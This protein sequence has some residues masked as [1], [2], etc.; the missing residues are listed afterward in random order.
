[1]AAT[2][3]D[4]QAQ[5]QDGTFREDLWFR[6]SV[7]KIDIPPLRERRE[8]VVPLAEGILADL[9]AELGKRSATLSA[10]ARARLAAYAFPGNVRE[11]RNLL[12]RALVLEQGPE[13]ALEMLMPGGAARGAASESDSGDFR[14]RAPPLTMDEVE[15]RYAR[16]V[17]EQ[18]GG[19]RM[20]AAKTLDISY[21]TFLKR[22]EGG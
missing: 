5:I 4:L 19:R 16:W 20:E 6:L 3:R 8:D 14:V 1:M 2:N 12:E 17:L 21:P 7:F 11:L 10:E 18:L 9:R 22:I 13:L 15:R